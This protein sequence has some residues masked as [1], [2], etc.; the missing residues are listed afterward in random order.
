MIRIEGLAF[1]YPARQP[2]FPHPLHSHDSTYL[3]SAIRSHTSP[4]LREQ[5]MLSHTRTANQNCRS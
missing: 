1:R 5:S 2:W 4:Q 3:P